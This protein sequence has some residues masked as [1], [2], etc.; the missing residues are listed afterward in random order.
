M[1]LCAFS[2]ICFCF[3]C[4][5]TGDWTLGF[6]TAQNLQPFFWIRNWFQDLA[7]AKKM[8][9]PLTYIPCPHQTFVFLFLKFWDKV[10]LSCPGWVWNCSPRLSASQRSGIR[11]MSSHVQIFLALFFSFL[12]ETGG[13]H[14]KQTNNITLSYITA[15]QKCLHQRFSDFRAL[16]FV[17]YIPKCVI[18]LVSF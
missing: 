15:L 17:K 9:M 13:S 18:L 1:F 5:G 10:P 3:V 12:I 11:D 14:I 4:H 16:L 7:L 8:L 2:W 6:H